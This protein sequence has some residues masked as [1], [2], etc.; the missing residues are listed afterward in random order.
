[1]ER[2]NDRT[3]ERWNDGTMK[4]AEGGRRK[5]EGKRNEG[6]ADCGLPTD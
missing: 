6:T 1:M 2:W 5:A 3:I 4:K